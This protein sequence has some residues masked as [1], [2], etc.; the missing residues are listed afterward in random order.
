MT[1]R[2]LK[3]RRSRLVDDLKKITENPEGQNGDLSEEQRAKFEDLKAEADTLTDRIAR[4]EYVDEAERRMDGERLEGGDGDDAWSRQIGKF[5]LQRAIAA[6]I[7]PRSV[8]AGLEI[9]VGQELTRRA[10]K[11]AEG[12]R[13]PLEAL[14]PRTEKRVATTGGDAGNLVGTDFLADQ[15]VDALRPRAAVGRLGGRTITGL[16]ADIAI[17]K[18]D[19]LTPAAEWVAENSALT[20][21]DHSFTQIAAEP[22]HLGLLTEWSRRTILQANPSVEQLVRADFIAKLAAGVDRAALKGS[23]GGAEPKGVMSYAGIGSVSLG[24]P[25]TVDW[26]DVTDAVAQ[27]E[28]A[29]ALM[30]S[31]GW[32]VNPYVKR[33]LRR[34]TKVSSDA[35]AGFIMDD[36]GMIEGYPSAVTSQLAGDPVSSPVV[37][38]ELLFGDYS[39]VITCLWGDAGADILV[40]P[41]ETTAYSKGNVQIR[42]FVDA[43]VVVRHEASFTE[44]TGISL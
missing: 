21:G 38:G 6:Q 2:E 23:G 13:V 4:Q 29:D 42:A 5:S 25:A 39:Q 28:A 34:T 14:A 22:H 41:Y 33:N 27:V 7:E 9:E 32:A 12:I 43:D 17:P 1:L 16:R 19:A 8:D 37:A 36:A 20:A 30:G 10:G 15:F 40:N 24:S 31:P 44:I 3:N 26:N 18:M 35:G 11:A